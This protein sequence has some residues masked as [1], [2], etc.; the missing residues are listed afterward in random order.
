MIIERYKSEGLAHNS[1]LVGAGNSAV[2]ID[3][4]R[5]CRVYAEAARSH[6]MKIKY[7]FETHRNEDYVI[8]SLPLAAL[9]GAEI[10]HGARP[11]WQY[12]R[13]LRDGQEFR[14][15]KLNITALFTPGHTDDSV[16]YVLT[17]LSTGKSP[18]AVFCGD[19]LFVQETG[20]VDFG[21]PAETPRMAANLYDSIFNRL[22]PLG[23]GV[24][25]Y[26]A[27]GGGSV[28]GGNIA[29]RDE[30]TLGLER[31]QNPALQIKDQAEFVRLK[32]S[33]V[34]DYPPYFRTMEKYNL[35]GP[36]LRD[37]PFPPPLSPSEFKNAIDQG[38]LV[39]D[40]NMPAAFGGAHIRGSYSIWLEGLPAW[41]GW[42]LPYD[43]PLLLVLEDRSHP[44]QAVRYLYRLGYDNIQGFLRDGIESWYNAGLPVENL[45]L[46]TVH[47]LR[48]RLDSEDDIFVLDVRDQAEWNSGRIAGSAHIFTGHIAGRLNEIPHQKP[49][50]VTCSVGHRGG[51]AASILLRA[52][53]TSLYNVLGGTIAWRQAGFP[54]VTL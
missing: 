12:G 47:Q 10:F 31:L 5:D 8:G 11:D 23:D 21:G 36:P 50:A 15:G 29:D 13:V 20:R 40:T 42:L 3:P 38:A 4:R 39:V 17:D 14:L 35:Q 34:L 22:L 28:C 18:A 7:I 46:M 25:L 26:P 41:A 48:A 52:G 24:L 49:V 19:T 51:V 43:K 1:Y 37:M 2:V 27:H 45:P 30:S 32:T 54:L 16:S 53:Y 44:E 9:T 6:G 33:E